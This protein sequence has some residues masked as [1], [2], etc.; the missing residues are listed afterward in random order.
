VIA[1]KSGQARH[2]CPRA[3]CGI[4]HLRR[5]CGIS[6]AS[7]WEL[8][9]SGSAGYQD[10][11]VWKQCSGV[12]S[13]SSGHHR[14]SVLPSRRGTVQVDYLCGF[15]W[16][17]VTS[18]VKCAGASAYDQYFAVIVHHCRSPITSPPVV[19]IRHRTPRTA[20]SNIKVPGYLTRPRTEQLSIRR[21]KHVWIEWQSQV[22]CAEVAPRRRSTLPY[23]RLNI[24]NPRPDRATDHEHI[25][26]RQRGV[27]WIPST[28]IHIRQPSPG[29][30]QW[31]ICIG[32]GQPNPRV[33]V[34]TGYE[35]LSVRKK[36]MA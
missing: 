33:Y 21:H 35:E 9:S 3:G 34:P 31:V 12:E 8:S 16:V 24:G 15:R 13:A 26:V 32:V 22:R 30:V 23:L 10:F 4:P 20:A 18:F 27:G 25:S 1:S 17:S 14:S 36:G 7:P 29:I 5:V 2:R 19:A 11:A 6:R 28:V